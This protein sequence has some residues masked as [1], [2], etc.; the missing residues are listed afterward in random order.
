MKRLFPHPI[1]SVTLVLLWF[2]LVNQLDARQPHSGRDPCH[3]DPAS[4]GAWWPDR[5]K[6]RRPF[7]LVAYSS[8]SSGT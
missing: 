8:S 5:P 7:A 6:V 1:L 3:L 2:L 4:F